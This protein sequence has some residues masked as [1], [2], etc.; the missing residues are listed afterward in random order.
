[1][2]Y[3]VGFIR[4]GGTVQ[5]YQIISKFGAK[6]SIFALLVCLTKLSWNTI[7]FDLSERLVFAIQCPYEASCCL[8]DDGMEDIWVNITAELGWPEPSATP[9]H[10]YSLMT[11]TSKKQRLDAKWTQYMNPVHIGQLLSFE[12]HHTQKQNSL[13]RPEVQP[14]PVMILQFFIIFNPLGFIHYFLPVTSECQAR[15]DCMQRNIYLF[16]FNPSC[17][18]VLS[19]DSYFHRWWRGMS[20]GWVKCKTPQ[21]KVQ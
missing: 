16:L 3:L 14:R 11:A 21:K 15:V 6:G 9:T 5:V 2:V 12:F 17:I 13:M 20:R 19:S 7:L 4:M 1:M 8:S 18:P 10:Q